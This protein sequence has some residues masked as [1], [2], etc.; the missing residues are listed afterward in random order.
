[1]K[2]I[3]VK[4][5]G[6]MSFANL[7]GTWNAILGL[8]LGIAIAISGTITMATSG[9]Y[10]IIAEVFLAI[11]IIIGS[12]VLVPL[13]AYAVGWLYGAVI[14]LVANLVVESAGGIELDVEESKL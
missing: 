11:A 9:D 6:I 2:R 8:F 5:I 3:T 14:A 4:H 12:L 13:F 1:M 7:I 10:G